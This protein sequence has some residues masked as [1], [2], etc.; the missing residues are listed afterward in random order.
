MSTISTKKLY[1][2]NYS[3]ESQQGIVSCQK[4]QF[5][6]LR[7]LLEMKN[8][9]EKLSCNKQRFQAWSELTI[10]EHIGV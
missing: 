7:S 1:F 8:H 4:M 9:L 3:E 10:T 6:D 2:L 5:D